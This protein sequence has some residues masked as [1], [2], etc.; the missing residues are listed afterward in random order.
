MTPSWKLRSFW[1]W[2]LVRSELRLQTDF[3]ISRFKHRCMQFGYVTTG[4]VLQQAQAITQ[5]NTQTN[6]KSS[7]PKKHN[8]NKPANDI[9]TNTNQTKMLMQWKLKAKSKPTS[10]VLRFSFSLLSASWSFANALV[11]HTNDD[12][13]RQSQNKLFSQTKTKTSHLFVLGFTY[14]GLFLQEM[15]CSCSVVPKIF[16]LK[17]KEAKR[18]VR[19]QT[20]SF[21]QIECLLIPNYRRS[22][23]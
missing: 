19:K 16:I 2:R 5:T 23:K 10:S 6:N 15:K 9:P 13:F 21:K 1:N 20:N 3:E 11:S 7:T 18:S 17:E 22:S 8:T 14:L 12:W 4:P